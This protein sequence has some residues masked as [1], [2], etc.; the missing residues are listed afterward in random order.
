[1]R[2]WNFSFTVSELVHIKPIKLQDY[3]RWGPRDF[4]N[5]PKGAPWA[6]C[7]TRYESDLPWSCQKICP[8]NCSPHQFPLGE[9]D[10]FAGTATQPVKDGKSWTCSLPKQVQING[11]PCWAEEHLMENI[12]HISQENNEMCLP[13]DGCKFLDM[14][15]SIHKNQTGHWEM[16]LPWAK[17]FQ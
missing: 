4:R 13:C 10:S 5:G 3:L 9:W 7:L 6:Q 17:K 2:F 8:R 15:I 11:E 16:P 14:E 12:F 1:M